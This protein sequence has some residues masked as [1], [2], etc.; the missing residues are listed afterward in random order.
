MKKY[1]C[2]GKNIFDADRK[3]NTIVYAIL[4]TREAFDPIKMAFS[5]KY[6][7]MQSAAVNADNAGESSEAG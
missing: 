6:S 3:M 5:K 4:T 7:K 2:S 1:K